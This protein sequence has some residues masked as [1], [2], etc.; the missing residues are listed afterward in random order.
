MRRVLR[1]TVG[2]VG[3]RLS[4]CR[5]VIAH[6]DAREDGAGGGDGNSGGSEED[7]AA[8]Q[9]IEDGAERVDGSIVVTRCNCCKVKNGAAAAVLGVARQAKDA[10]R[11]AQR[12]QQAAG[13][14]KRVVK[15]GFGIGHAC[16]F[17]VSSPCMPVTG[18][19]VC[20][21]QRRMQREVAGGR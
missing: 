18:C 1:A 13:A 7:A 21:K 9:K 6:A 17:N 10:R 12:G 3:A 15:T 2:E 8:C 11:P 4:N 20:R 5:W 14:G 16:N 19:C